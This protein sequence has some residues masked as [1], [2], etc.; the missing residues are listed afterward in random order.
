MKYVSLTWKG[1]IAENNMEYS[2]VI[3]VGAR[4]WHVKH[5]CSVPIK[6]CRIFSDLCR[7]HQD[8]TSGR[9]VRIKVFNSAWP[10]DVPSGIAKAG[11]L[12]YLHYL[13]LSLFHSCQ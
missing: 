5:Q 3:I 12:I 1:P 2:F 13:P 7:L 11:S 4:L 6:T 9:Y 8:K 10:C